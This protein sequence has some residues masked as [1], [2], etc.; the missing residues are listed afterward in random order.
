MNKV[1]R[2]RAILELL[3]RGPVESQEELQ[4]FLA[5]RGFEAGQATLSR[6]IRELG[7]VKTP[8]GYA[9]ASGAAAAEPVLP[10]VSRLVREFVVDVRLAQNLLVLKTSVGSA[11][12]V[13]AALDSE[14]W[15]EVVGTIAGDDTIL[16]IS[17]DN[18]T[19]QQL[20]RR[21]HGMLE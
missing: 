8:D 9:A 5:R 16:V 17:P 21:I 19:A 14:D 10:S 4:G 3:H 2:Q 13:A 6:D 1:A 20:V 12:P 18:K 11:Q 7:L 15:P